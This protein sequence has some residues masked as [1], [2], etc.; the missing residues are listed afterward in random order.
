MNNNILKKIALYIA[1][2]GIPFIGGVIA[3]QVKTTHLTEITQDQ[4]Q[5]LSSLVAKRLKLAQEFAK[6][7]W[8]QTLPIDN[9]T[10]EKNQLDQLLTQANQLNIDPSQVTNFF[11]AQQE[12]YKMVMIENFDVWVA[13]DIH[14]HDQATDL[15][16]LN[17]Q[18]NEVDHQILLVL[19]KDKGAEFSNKDAL[20]ASLAK[21]LQ[22][23][24]FSREVIDA[25]VHF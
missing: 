24:G 25:A 3:D 23:Q 6:T 15:K 22:A 12:A 19:Q 17:Q 8:N 7:H 21:D 1:V 13:Q 20:K 18:L 10:Q 9:L 14:Q 11:L 16:S 4:N 5:Q 2:L